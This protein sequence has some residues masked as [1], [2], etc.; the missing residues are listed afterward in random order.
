[1]QRV[2]LESNVGLFSFYVYISFVG[3]FPHLYIMHQILTKGTYTRIVGLFSIYISRFYIFSS[4][5]GLF[6]M[7]VRPP[8]TLTHTPDTYCADGNECAGN[9]VVAAGATGQAQ[10]VGQF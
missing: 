10:K 5:I 7:Q 2:F 1:M 4:Y 9:N 6:Y 8:L 3:V